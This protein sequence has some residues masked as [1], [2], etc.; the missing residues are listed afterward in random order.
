MVG[1]AQILLV[2]LPSVLP[3]L[4][5]SQVQPGGED[6]Q[7]HLECGEQGTSKAR[8]VLISQC[9]PD[10]HDPGDLTPIEAA[11]ALY[12]QSVKELIDCP[13]DCGMHP[14][15]L[16]FAHASYESGSASAIIDTTTGCVTAELKGVTLSYGC[17]PCL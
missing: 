9:H 3:F 17:L 7:L 12:Q 11:I 15:C 6:P 2:V 1:K 4:N 13:Q 5:N 14:S 8:R 16:P 10:L